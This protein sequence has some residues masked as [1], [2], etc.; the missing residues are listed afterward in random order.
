MLRVATSVLVLAGC[1]QVLGVDNT[2]LRD[3]PVVDI[4]G[5]GV[6][7]LED[8]CRSV[9]NPLQGD[10]DADGVGDACD[11]CP[12]VANT[13][14]DEVGD[15]DGIGDAC[16]PHPTTDGDCLIVLDS[17]RDPSLFASNWTLMTTMGGTAMVEAGDVMLVPGAGS[18]GIFANGFDA[19]AALEVKATADLHT[20]SSLAAVASVSPSMSPAVPFFGYLCELEP[21][22]VAAGVYTESNMLQTAADQF[23]EPPVTHDALL[24]LTFPDPTVSPLVVQ[25]RADWGVAVATAPIDISPGDVVP[26]GASGVFAR[27]DSATIDAVALYEQL[28]PCPDPI[29]R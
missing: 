13:S 9:P 25:C 12:L 16:D 24:R 20:G 10:E 2:I 18:V 6:P 11:N 23:S 1:N 14:Q 19:L 26:P 8:N 7:D 22:Q 3:A 21:T 28:S 5:D 15:H 29:I 27:G 17:F 4:D